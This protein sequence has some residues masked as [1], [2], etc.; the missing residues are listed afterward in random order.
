[1]RK[2]EDQFKNVYMIPQAIYKVIKSLFE[3]DYYFRKKWR[4]PI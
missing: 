2:K 1:M 3:I 4:T